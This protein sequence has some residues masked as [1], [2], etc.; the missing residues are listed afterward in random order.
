MV[1]ITTGRAERIFSHAAGCR[2]VTQPLA[3]SASGY[4]V[5]FVKEDFLKT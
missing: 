4:M 5:I 2:M 1:K 3:I